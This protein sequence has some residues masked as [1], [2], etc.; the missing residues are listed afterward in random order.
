MTH[1]YYIINLKNSTYI[2][3]PKFNVSGHWDQR[4]PH[5]NGI[6]PSDVWIIKNW[7]DEVTDVGIPYT[8]DL[9]SSGMMATLFVDID[10]FDPADV[11]LA[12]EQLHREHDIVSLK[13]FRMT[14]SQKI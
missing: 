9:C 8:Y 2:E 6:D 12:K 7:P 13:I 3:D 10:K 5:I 11:K 1:T 14:K 4:Y